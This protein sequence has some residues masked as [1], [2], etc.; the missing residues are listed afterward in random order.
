MFAT[1]AA[2]AGIAALGAIAGSAPAQARTNF[3]GMWS[4]VVV[5]E[6]GDCDR[7]YRYPIRINDD[8]SLVNAGSSS[9]DISGKVAR[10]GKLVV[11]LSYGDKSATGR[12]RLSGAAG[13]GRWAGGACAGT[14]T[15]ERR[16]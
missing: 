8:G 12:G 7:A 14:W 1:A 2:A 13:A 4:V 16:G 11:R 9:F 10:D 6:Q 15:A 3:D 5:T